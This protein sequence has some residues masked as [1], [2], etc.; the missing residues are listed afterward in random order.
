MKHKKLAIIALAFSAAWCQDPNAQYWG[1]KATPADLNI[2]CSID[3]AARTA[4]VT[5]VNKTD[6][7][8]YFAR[9]GPLIDYELVVTSP[10][11]KRLPKPEPPSPNETTAKLKPR[12]SST[13]LIA[14]GP[15]EDYTAT[16]DLAQLVALPKDGGK[17][18]IRIGQSLFERED[19][20]FEPNPAQTVWCK[21]I[22][23]TFPPLNQ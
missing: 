9:S 1:S 19:R 15:K 13:A 7:R 11:G 20:M 17:F 12:S 10:S 4:T 16:F 14:L 3:E 2:S 5:I 23:V 8:R 18:H 21:P 22:D 6:K